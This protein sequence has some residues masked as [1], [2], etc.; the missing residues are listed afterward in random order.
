[1]C[2]HGF[3][4]SS[5]MKF[6]LI[7]WMISTRMKFAFIGWMSGS[8][9]HIL[10]LVRWR[11]DTDSLGMGATPPV[12]AAIHVECNFEDRK[13]CS[14]C[15]PTF[16][17]AA[18]ASVHLSAA[19]KHSTMSEPELTIFDVCSAE[20]DPT[21]AENLAGLLQCISDSHAGVSQRC[22]RHCVYSFA[23]A[24]Q[25]LTNVFL[26]FTSRPPAVSPAALIPST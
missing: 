13:P 26:C 20:F 6:A 25:S 22:S 19:T 1:M 3:F 24:Q 17:Q 5:R 21:Q 8:R 15:K 12:L 16:L 23:I 10:T 2:S 14:F 7:G 18:S 9:S 4:L 11:S